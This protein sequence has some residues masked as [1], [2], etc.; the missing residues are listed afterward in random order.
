MDL[1]SVRRKISFDWM[2]MVK[3]NMFLYAQSERLRTG[4]L[5][6]NE[7]ESAQSEPVVEE[8]L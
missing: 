6:L 5:S 3:G 4:F 8:V 7:D 1:P 2:P